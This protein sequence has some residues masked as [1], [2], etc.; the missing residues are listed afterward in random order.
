M[1]TIRDEQFE[2]LERVRIEDFLVRHVVKFFP[3]QCAALGPEGTVQTVRDGLADAARHGLQDSLDECAYV[4]VMFL[5][6]RGFAT[7]PR[8]PWAR[9][10][11][12][13]AVGEPPGTRG[14]RL[15][16]AAM[17]ELERMVRAGA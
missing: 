9:A 15:Y 2:L 10:A 4:D 12:G 8:L 6:G 1:H 14:A 3:E 7:D 13:A 16:A 17:E 11:L 5:F